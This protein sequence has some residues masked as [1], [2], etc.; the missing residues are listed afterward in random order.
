[1]KKILLGWMLILS[2][3]FV[4]AQAR[5]NVLAVKIDSLTVNGTKIK[6]N[7]PFQT[8]VQMPTII[9]EGY[10]YNKKA[11]I[12]LTLSYYIWD[13]AIYNASISS[14]GSYT[15]PVYMANEGGKVVIFIDDKNYFQRFNIR[16]Y[17]VG[18]T[19]DTDA[20]F[21]G[22]TVAD[23]KIHD[24]IPAQRKYLIGYTNRF[25]G[26]VLASGNV[27]IGTDTPRAA[28]TVNG[29]IY[30]KRVKVTAT[31]WPDHVF[32]QDYEL[33]PLEKVQEFIK[34]HGHLPD[35]PSAKEVEKEG[36]DVG[37]INKKLLQKIEEL[38]LY[39]LEMK[40]EN[41]KM[42]NRISVLEKQK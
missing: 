27:A 24:T 4:S 22:W 41:E 11:T 23:E 13:N 40:Q 8:A 29:E 31:G 34:Q 17:S 19:A 2:S 36:Q 30:A 5:Y 20:N 37:E 12:G 9:L 10:S 35:I 18:G 1:M 6:T 14:F 28:L 38:T 42:K 39:L 26:N 15:P 21:T 3:I 25:A 7:L 16:T 33:R 32:G